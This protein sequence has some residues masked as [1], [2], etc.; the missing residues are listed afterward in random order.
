MSFPALDLYLKYIKWRSTLRVFKTRRTQYTCQQK[1]KQKQWFGRKRNNKHGC[2]MT[3]QVDSS[4]VTLG[5][6][7]NV[8]TLNKIHAVCDLKISAYPLTTDK[9]TSYPFVQST[10]IP[11]PSP[12]ISSWRTWCT[13]L[14]RTDVARVSVSPCWEW[15]VKHCFFLNVWWSKL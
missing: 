7:L 12:H 6:E 14:E 5:Q 11:P 2:R 3:C 4:G 13:F 1:Q 15:D 9:W 8:T 10:T